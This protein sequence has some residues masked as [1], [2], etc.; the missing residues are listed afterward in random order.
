VV[1]CCEHDNETLGFIKGREFLDQLCNYQLLKRYFVPCTGWDP[2]MQLLD[3]Y[4]KCFVSIVA[5]K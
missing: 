5:R 2:V 1:V 3:D 4:Y